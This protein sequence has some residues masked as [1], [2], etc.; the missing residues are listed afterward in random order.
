MRG[1]VAVCLV[2]ILATTCV[3]VLAESSPDWPQYRGPSRDG[4][5]SAAKAP[6]WPD[7]GPRVVWRQPLGAAFSQLVVGGGA[8]FTGTSDDKSEYLVRL[9]A[10]TG[11]EAWRL[12]LGPVFESAEFGNGPRSTPTLDGET[13]YQLGARGTLVAARAADGGEVFRVD[14]TQRFGAAVPRFGYSGSPLVAGDL[15]VL[16]VGGGEQ[17]WLAALDKKTGETRWTS[18]KGGAGYNSPMLLRAGKAEELLLVH[19]KNVVGL[20]LAGRE[21]WSH[22]LEDGAVAMPLVVGADRL[23]V[24]HGSDAGCEMLGLERGEGGTQVK[25]LWQNRNMRNHF[26]SSVL[27]GEHIYGFDNATLKCLSAAT[28]E[29][30]WAH[31]GLGKGSL[32]G[33]GNRL[34]VVSDQGAVL[35]VEATPEAYRELG[36]LTAL[37]GKSWTA[38]S[39]ARGRLYVRNLTEA[40]CLDFGG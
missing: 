7:G 10:A 30:A 2:S 11:K 5:A 24:S 12:A 14:L 37:S 25:T 40:A 27:V 16:E 29:L 18:G 39:F 3:R 26:N 38:P 23:F 28:G 19:G 21:L 13:V 34:V 32:L 35:L 33:A 31:R 9:D 36:S 6:S 20:D 4:A 15:L 1:I 17:G 22:A 8:V